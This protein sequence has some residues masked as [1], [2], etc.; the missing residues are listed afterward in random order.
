MT[1]TKQ[2]EREA[3]KKIREIVESLGEGSYIAAAFEGCFD[4]A[5]DNIENDFA[6]SMK[7]RYDEADRTIGKLHEEMN[8]IKAEAAKQKQYIES[9]EKRNELVSGMYNERLE[10]GLQLGIR[11][12]IAED[13]KK[14]LKRQITE[15]KAKLYD[16]M[17][18]ETA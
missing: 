14:E 9:L 16:F 18:R 6:C 15:L 4:D 11:L 1:A 13:E 12:D 7:Q 2:Q 17:A 3:L 5:E 8:N 10:D